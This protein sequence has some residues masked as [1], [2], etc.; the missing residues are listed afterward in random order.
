MSVL[1]QLQYLDAKSIFVVRSVSQLFN[2]IATPIAYRRVVLNE[3]IVRPDAQTLFSKALEHIST[4]TKHVVVRNN[5]KPS[6]IRKILSRIMRLSSVTL[7]YVQDDS[8]GASTW[9]IH[10]VLDYDQLRTQNTKV[11]IENLP[12]GGSQSDLHASLLDPAFTRHLV[13]LKLARP[14]PPL[15]TKVDSLKRL[16]VQCSSLET[17]HYE[18]LGQGTSFTFSAGECL[19]PLSN[20]VLKSYDW[21][22]SAEEVERHWNLSQMKS[23]VLVSVPVLNFLNS[24]SPP[25]LCNLTRLQV[26]DS[27]AH[28]SDGRE[29]ATRR[30]DLLVRKHIRALEVLDITCH[31]NLFHIDSI[32][33]HGGS[34]RQVHFRDHIGFT[35]DDDECPTLRAED[36][37][38]LGQ[39]LPF[40]H[41]LELD[42][43][44]AL[45]Y[46]PEFL[47][48]IASFP[49][50]QTLIL[51]VQTLLRATEKDDP[52][53]DRDYESAMQMFSCLVRL[54]EKSNPDL[55]WKSITINVG[56]WRRVMLRRM[57][58]EWR[59]KNARGIFAE[60]CF[61][62]EKDEN[63]RYR[64][65]EQECH[66]GSQY[67]ST[68][69]L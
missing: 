51:H 27:L 68:S 69:Q 67:I 2:S 48:G 35:D 60:R 63:G 37:T 65:A 19:P 31:T 50:L 53:R 15:T 28:A 20:L 44:V 49:M 59:R 26:H 11:N 3:L 46:P 7:C 17:L 52:A 36:V 24:I 8:H 29:E 38:R 9:P 4:Y 10:D 58:P 6:G 61:V 23:L 25:D 1:E 43:D 33:Q 16:L 21:T 47:R 64:V 32:L 41:T 39:G 30:L 13:S 5:L 62:L 22:H 12:L 57:G 14:T 18:D 55:A 45:C 40:V 34:L 42:M 54:R 66:D 56:G